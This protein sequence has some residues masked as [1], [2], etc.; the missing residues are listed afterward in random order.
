MKK[1]QKP[2]GYELWFAE[3]K[4]YIGKILFVR[5]G[6]RLSLQYHISKDESI[7]LYKGRMEFWSGTSVNSLNKTILEEGEARHIPPGLLHRFCALTDCFIFEVSTP[8]PDDVVRVEDD[9]D[10]A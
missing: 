8:H 1:V 10:R 9:Y 4:H 7:Y 6:S 5:A 3:T 2:W